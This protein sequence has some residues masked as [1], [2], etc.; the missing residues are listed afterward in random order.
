MRL[1]E[2][3][4][5]LEPDDWRSPAPP[6]VG[7]NGKPPKVVLAHISFTETTDTLR[8][9]FCPE[10]LGKERMPFDVPIP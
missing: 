7:R 10:L 8:K 4:A 5:R 9:K 1:H 6:P 3:L 2:K